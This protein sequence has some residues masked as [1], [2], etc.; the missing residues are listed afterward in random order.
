MNDPKFLEL[1]EEYAKEIADPK[2]LAE[3]DQYLRQLEAEGRGEEVYGK[4]VQ[5]VVPEPAFAVKTKDANTGVKVVIN[6]CSSDK[7]AEVTE[8]PSSDSS[9]PGIFVDIPI[10]V[11]KEKKAAGP[12]DQPCRVW[13]VAVHPKA[14]ERA[15]ISS[16]FRDTLVESVSH[17]MYSGK[18]QI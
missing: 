18:E 8:R 5:L 13:D 7:V 10:T 1:F 6:I 17:S 15:A 14:I 2:A 9:S 16:V 3:H 4:G 11:G 12:Q